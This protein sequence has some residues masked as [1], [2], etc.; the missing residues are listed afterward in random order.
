MTGRVSLVGAGPGSPDLLTLRAV[1]KLQEAELVLYDGLVASEALDLASQAHRFYVGKRVGRKSIEQET[2]NQLMI[3]AARRGQS[4]VRLKCGDP[5]VLGRG[6]EEA[7]ALARAGVPF[8]V[9]PGISSAIA[10]PELAGIPVTH[11]GLA[12]GFLVIAGHA[13]AAYGPALRS[14]E[15]GAVTLVVLMGL[16]TRR[17]IASL[18]VERGWAR[19]TPAAILFDASMPGSRTWVGTLGELGVAELPEDIAGC[20]AAL[21]IGEVVSMAAEIGSAWADPF[22]DLLNAEPAKPIKSFSNAGE[23]RA[24]GSGR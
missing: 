8:E 18:L 12:S 7:I 3:R 11:R 20:P 6:G 19:T 5:F 15:P 9:V 16:S 1:R 2:I 24:H 22:S 13:E 23:R 10:G 21:C 14:L 17:P 4:V